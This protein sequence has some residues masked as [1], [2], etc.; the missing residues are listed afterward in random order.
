MSVAVPAAA[1]PAGRPDRRRPFVALMPSRDGEHV[2]VETEGEDR[3]TVRRAKA[4]EYLRMASRQEQF[5]RQFDVL[6]NELDAWV[7]S[8]PGAARAY[9]TAR[10]EALLF[11]AV[12]D[13]AE[14]DP[15]FEDRLS[16]LDLRLHRDPDLDLIRLNV[17]AFPNVSRDV[18]NDFLDPDFSLT[19]AG[20]ADP[21]GDR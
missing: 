18:L 19:H 15:D 8:E 9:L 12:T 1:P 5:E 16:E 10:D 14:C 21:T 3:F 4:V 11:V 2:T 6:L 13:R 20:D 7:R 17:M